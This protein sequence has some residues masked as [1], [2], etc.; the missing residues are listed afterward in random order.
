[1]HFFYRDILWLILK[2]NVFNSV[3]EDN[4]NTSFKKNVK[5]YRRLDALILNS[6]YKLKIYLS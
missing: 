1:M 2:I 6:D 3:Y 4:I 5:L